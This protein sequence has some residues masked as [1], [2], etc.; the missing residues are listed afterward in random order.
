MNKL[1]LSLLAALTI[2]LCSCQQQQQAQTQCTPTYVYRE[3]YTARE[4]G[5]MCNMPEG[6]VYSWISRGK[7]RLRE[8]LS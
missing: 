3:G 7:R 2:G 8:V 5:R 6:T 1:C 4:I